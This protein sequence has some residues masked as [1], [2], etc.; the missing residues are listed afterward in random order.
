MILNKV[1]IKLLTTMRCLS[2]SIHNSYRGSEFNFFFFS[3]NIISQTF[4]LFSGL[5]PPGLIGWDPLWG[6]LP[7]NG[8]QFTE[9]SC[10]RLNPWDKGFSTELLSIVLLLSQI[11]WNV[12]RSFF[13]SFHV[14]KDDYVQFSGLKGWKIKWTPKKLW[15]AL[16]EMK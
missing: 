6:A 14:E 12:K 8:I 10:P 13:S 7:S 4:A 16:Q 2:T 5:T 11:W 3:I 9:Y 15:N 1:K